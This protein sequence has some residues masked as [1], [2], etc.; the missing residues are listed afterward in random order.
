MNSPDFPNRELISLPCYRYSA[1]D[2]RNRA[3]AIAIW[4]RW[5][6]AA[7]GWICP[8]A[9]LIDPSCANSIHTALT[10]WLAGLLAHPTQH[11]LI[12]PVGKRRGVF[13]QFAVEDLRLLQQQKR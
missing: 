10:T 6:I 4:N 11:Q 7:A 1:R 5:V 9:R 13:R 8:M 12:E 3:P 2:R